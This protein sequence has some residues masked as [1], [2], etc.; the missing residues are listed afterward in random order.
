MGRSTIQ[1]SDL[2]NVYFSY[3]KHSDAARNWDN[4]SGLVFS[5]FHY[6]VNV[7]KLLSKSYKL[8][9]TY[10]PLSLPIADT[11]VISSLGTFS[12]GGDTM[13]TQRSHY[14]N[15]VI[16][17]P[18][19]PTNSAT[20]SIKEYNESSGSWDNIMDLYTGKT[21]HHAMNDKYAVMQIE[22]EPYGGDNGILKLRKMNI[23][24]DTVS[25]VQ[26]LTV[27]RSSTSTNSSTEQIVTGKLSGKFYFFSVGTST[28]IIF[29]WNLE[30][31]VLTE[32]VAEQ[33]ILP[34]S[35]FNNRSGRFGAVF[36]VDGDTF[37]SQD[38]YGYY[39]IYENINDTWTYKQTI[40]LYNEVHTH[41]GYGM[42]NLNYKS[43]MV[44]C[45]IM[46]HGNRAI[47]SYDAYD[48]TNFNG[49]RI[50]VIEKSGETW[51]KTAT[52][53]AG[54]S[55]PLGRHIYIEDDVILATSSE[56]YYRDRLYTFTYSN[57]S[58]SGGEN[59]YITLSSL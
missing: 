46:I 41:I 24:N 53:T 44:H 42:Q 39:Y 20:V 2:S 1:A 19:G 57:G 45:K 36:D 4:G 50:F 23:E 15:R 52:L 21:Q 31:N 33:E 49:G 7:P 37:I 29:V 13:R 34:G 22:W 48:S 28:K 10:A 6:D 51:N 26:D 54:S 43:L 59:N 38:K 12:Y 11:D 18:E 40:N 58:W 14:K 8:E 5:S 56:S 3:T 35:K 25:D 55:N 17:T 9:E 30:T 47:F 16:T 32:L 27:T